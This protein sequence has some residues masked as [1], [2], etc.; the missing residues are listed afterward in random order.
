M[1]QSIIHPHAIRLFVIAIFL[2]PWTSFGAPVNAEDLPGPFLRSRS[3]MHTGMI[4]RIAVD[5][6]GRYLLSCSIDK[7]AKLWNARSGELLRTF[8]PPAGDDQEGRLYACALSPDGRIAAVSGWTGWSITGKCSVY[9]FNTLSGSLDERLEELPYIVADIAFSHD[10]ALMAV[11]FFGGFGVRIYRVAGLQFEKN[12]GGFGESCTHCTFDCKGRLA[13]A[14]A[15]G[16]VRVY[17]DNFDRYKDIP[18]INGLAPFSISFSA[19]GAKLAVGYDNSAA[20]TIYDSPS[21]T[22]VQSIPDTNDLPGCMSLVAWSPT[23]TD[24]YSV[25]TGA[26][27]RKY[28]VSIL[29]RYDNRGGVCLEE[30]VFKSGVLMDIKTLPDNSVAFAGLRPQLGRIDLA[31]GEFFSNESNLVDFSVLE[32]GTL[33]ISPN[34]KEIRCSIPGGSFLFSIS[35]RAI[36]PVFKDLQIKRKT[37]GP[38]VLSEWK[39]SSKLVINGHEIKIFDKSEYCLSSATDDLSGR[40]IIGSNWNLNRIDS[41]GNCAWRKPTPGEVWAIAL[42][43]EAD[44]CA[45]ALGDGTIRWYRMSDGQELLALAISRDK[46][47]WVTWT[48]TGFW[49]ASDRGGEL[50]GKCVNHG[51]SHA[52]DML[53]VSRIGRD[54]Y[55]PR[56]IMHLFDFYDISF[57]NKPSVFILQPANESAARDSIIAVHIKMMTPGTAPITKVL[58]AVNGN[59]QN[60]DSRGLA[61][62]SDKEIIKEDFPVE[63]VLG[64]NKLSVVACN[65]WGCS[66]TAK[67]TVHRLGPAFT[68]QPCVS[69]EHLYVLSIGISH[70]Q[71]NIQPL[72]F[73]GKDAVDF[74]KIW[75]NQTPCPYQQ[76]IPIVLI[77]KKATKR[78]ILDGLYRL[79]ARATSQDMI[80]L[81]MAGHAIR[82]AQGR[83]CFI[84]W[85]AASGK[86]YAALIMDK[87]LLGPLEKSGARVLCFF[88]ACNAGNISFDLNRQEPHDA[89][90]A[91]NGVII[92]HSTA[93][94]QA[95]NENKGWNNGVFTKALFEGLRGN[96]DYSARGVVTVTMISLYIS[97]RVKELTQG[98]QTPVITFPNA[99]TDFPLALVR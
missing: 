16:R 84:P 77:N 30:R 23:S 55:N 72:T 81:F 12:L 87:E 39:K 11:S 76:V 63:L 65:R 15:D 34:A 19:D 50:I 64:T 67:V 93:P 41:V 2:A 4:G 33:S 10:G 74:V 13:V 18:A 58:I 61:I 48:P 57:A 25:I 45:A 75:S 1:V 32:S 8:Y 43:L 66:D 88:D 99:F 97:E 21:L 17:A 35:D 85:E 7:T 91:R 98:L 38:A 51:P 22:K 92:L 73:P 80:M 89:G 69:T 5:Q 40:V 95:A 31:S 29:K 28:G 54:G 24:L 78:A 3:S 53:P 46:K 70:Y 79:C 71:G 96:A 86:D 56:A 94:F 36:R 37:I 42:A 83:F 90:K 9:L 27:S 49:D 68:K 82:D 47:R 14:S 52:A 26:F 20:I 44:L 59:P 60:T 6:K 62:V